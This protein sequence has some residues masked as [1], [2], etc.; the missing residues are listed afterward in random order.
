MLEWLA[1][2][3][4]LSVFTGSIYVVVSLGLTLTLAVIK[5]P[6]FAHAEFLTVGAY[7]GVVV[8]AIYPNNLLVI[9]AAAFLFCAG[10]H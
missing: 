7:V 6:N 5:L 3:I 2:S 4:L 10:L 9:G 1:G 8:S